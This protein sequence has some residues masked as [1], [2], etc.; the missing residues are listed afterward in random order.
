MII[1]SVVAGGYIIY[2]GFCWEMVGI[3]YMLIPMTFVGFMA[4]I[5]AE[6]KDRYVFWG[7]FVPGVFYTLLAHFATNTGILTMS[8]SC[9]IP[10]AASL[11]L[12]GQHMQAAKESWPA[13]QPNG[14]DTA[15]MQESHKYSAVCGT[16]LAVLI[17][18]QFAGGIWQRVTYVWGDEKL[19]K[20]TVA[21]EEG[22]LKGIHT[23]EENSLL[24]E[25]VMQDMEDLQLTREDKLFVVGI[26]PWMYLNTEAECA[27]YSTWETLE[28]DPL[29][30]TY[31]EV[32]PEKQPTVI[33][34]YDYDESILDTE[35][36]S[37]FLNKGY[38][39]MMMRRGLVLLRR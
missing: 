13:K 22:P 12:I 21:A 32:R 31:Y 39:P 35:F 4:Y 8:A 9:M 17:A 36:G 15:L 29:I 38:E 1:E 25:D 3:N 16:V 34:C 28:T 30:F 7:W 37:A 10:S 14:Y 24:Y 6:K 23:S 20:L 19:P 2:Y 18:V 11:V 33:Y 27:A 5:T 26:A